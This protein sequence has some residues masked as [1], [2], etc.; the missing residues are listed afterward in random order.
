MTT[1]FKMYCGDSNFRSYAGSI[2]F[3]GSVCGDFLITYLAERKGRRILMIWSWGVSTVGIILASFS[4]NKWMLL[5]SLFFTGFGLP[6]CNSLNMILINE[7][8]GEKFRQKAT[9]IL[10]MSWSTFAIFLAGTVY[11]IN[12]WRT[13]YIYILAIQAALIFFANFYVCESPMFLYSLKADD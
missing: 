6:P 2:I 11:L 8:S 13:I 4:V 7:Q 1:D 9:T 10:L 5:P 12:D 3:A